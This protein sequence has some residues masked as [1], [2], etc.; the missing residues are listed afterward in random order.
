MV[1]QAM[2]AEVARHFHFSLETPFK[3][4]KPEHRKVLLYGAGDLRLPMRYLKGGGDYEVEGHF[5]GVIP[6]LTRLHRES[7]SD[8]VKEGVETYMREISCR[9]C[10][11]RRLRPESL[12][13]TLGGKNIIDATQL[14]VRQALDYFTELKLGEQARTVS[15]PILKELKERLGFLNDVGL[16]YLSLDRASSTLSGGEAQ[17]IH[18]AT[19]IGSS[20]VGV[21]Y[22]LDEPSIGLHQRDNA[23]LLATLKRLRDLGNTVLVVEHDEETMIEA[24]YL[25]DVG[26]GAG[27]HGGYIVAKGTPKEVMRNPKSLTGQYLSGRRR[28]EVPKQRHAGNGKWLELKGAKLNN[29][30]GLDV[31]LP[32]GALTAVTGV[33]GSGKSTLV[34]DT[35]VPALRHALWRTRHKPQGYADLKGFEHLDKV[36]DIDQSAIG[37][38]PRSNPATYTGIFDEIRK[39]FA[40]T[41]EAKER[42][43]DPG[44]FSF[45][46]KGGRCE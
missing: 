26:P 4:L 42:G 38:T 15:K 14:S 9:A 17:R 29:L 34:Q 7:E 46:V 6:R 44:R 23:R 21:L 12:A 30:K 24:D 40:A 19:Q 22:I 39:L 1:L 20:L 35:L 28:V 37:R 2:G 32:L 16:D 45:N 25:I 3:H 33:S 18:L 36:I 31:A 5:E 10:G 8:T 13:V 41:R 43:Y 27:V 11:G